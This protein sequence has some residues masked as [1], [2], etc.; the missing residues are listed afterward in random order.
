[1]ATL[2]DMWAQGES[3]VGV[4]QSN[5]GGVLHEISTFQ[6][7]VT[8]LLSNE[9]I[10]TIVV[11]IPGFV[12]LMGYRALLRVTGSTPT[13]TAITVFAIPLLIAMTF[14]PWGFDSANIASDLNSVDSLS[15]LFELGPLLKYWGVLIASGILGILLAIVIML[16]E[17]MF[18]SLMSEIKSQW[19]RN[20][21]VENCAEPRHS[22]GRILRDEPIVSTK[23]D[24]LNRIPL[25]EA[26][27]GVAV[28]EEDDIRGLV[29]GVHGSWGSGKSSLINMALEPFE[30]GQQISDGDAVN[31]PQVIRFNPWLY[32]TVEQVL[33]GFFEVLR[34]ELGTKG[35]ASSG[36]LRQSE[37]GDAIAL[38]AKSLIL[39][40]SMVG[41]ADFAKDERVTNGDVGGQLIAD[42]DSA[43]REL[44]KHLAQLGHRVI[45]VIDDID[46]LEAVSIGR[47]LQ[48]VRLNAAFVNVTYLLCF[49]RGPVEQAIFSELKMP[50]SSYLEKIIQISIDLPPLARGTH[51]QLVRE[52]IETGIARSLNDPEIYRFDQM[53]TSGFSELFESPRHILQFINALSFTFPM[54]RD[55][56]D[57]LDFAGIE[58]IRLRDSS[59][60]ADLRA[61][62]R[63]VLEPRS[64]EERFTEEVESSSSTVGEFIDPFRPATRRLC[65]FLFPQ[66]RD[67]S[68]TS[69][70]DQSMFNTLR[71]S[72]RVASPEFFEKFFLFATPPDGI[73]ERELKKAFSFHDVSDIASFI[74]DTAEQSKLELFL[75]RALDQAG[76]LHPL[77][78]KG[79]IAAMCRLNYEEKRFHEFDGF[80]EQ[81]GEFVR[82]M[83]QIVQNYDGDGG[84]SELMISV[85]KHAGHLGIVTR[86]LGSL[87]PS[88]QGIDPSEPFSRTELEGVMQ[89]YTDQMNDWS[90]TGALVAKTGH[91]LDAV[92]FLWGTW[93]DV[94][95]PKAAADALLSDTHGVIALISGFNTTST[96]TRDGDLPVN[97]TF[98]SRKNLGQFV[99]LE[100]L[101]AIAERII[102]DPAI[103]LS[104]DHRELLKLYL[105][106][107]D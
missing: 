13:V 63:L 33:A 32:N 95:G 101:D 55:E 62:E 53:Y 40:P 78:A 57:E 26:L 7:G 18:R 37:V 51:R 84:P 86:Y 98:P 103:Q 77:V 20:S 19:G 4:T 92:F 75:A 36:T 74:Y 24:Q 68:G 16:L 107:F 102:S 73:S 76:G 105:S 29:I 97:I 8:D 66:L 30:S 49:D 59:A 17:Q 71:Q 35:S 12:A 80:Q 100:K 11:V 88:N 50:G 79:W 34:S 14:A 61:N 89:T 2:V 28:G 65:Q 72:K 69:G 44:N 3:A 22:T 15:D 90:R 31:A 106:K 6:L 41:R 5:F 1:M 58:A 48:L 52:A 42:L 46:R 91:A 54:L 93:A 56:L 83:H 96:T 87:E 38:M 81:T 67:Q 94:S 10:L 104:D 39:P 21:I 23:D 43:R 45:I 64:V 85:I 9:I 60:Y 70:Y 82:L 47:L 27:R 99:S 25:A